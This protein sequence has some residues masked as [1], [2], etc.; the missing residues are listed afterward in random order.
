[1]KTN[2]IIVR[3][4]KFTCTIDFGEIIDLPKDGFIDLAQNSYICQNTTVLDVADANTHRMTNFERIKAMSID[5]LTEIF[6][7]IAENDVC[8]MNGHQWC[9]ECKFAKFCDVQAGDVR[10]WLESEV[11]E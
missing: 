10:E 5:E 3:T 4:D 1:M 6:E 7:A 11:T 2:K 8:L 9:S